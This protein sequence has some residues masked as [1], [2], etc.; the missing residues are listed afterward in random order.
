MDLH[1]VSPVEFDTAL[2]EIHFSRD[3][4]ER[5]LNV[6]LTILHRTMGHRRASRSEQWCLNDIATGKFIRYIDDR[7]TIVS[8]VDMVDAANKTELSPETAWKFKQLS[9]D[10]DAVLNASLALAEIELD[11]Q[12]R[13]AVFLAR[14]GWARYFSTKGT[15]AHTHTSM[16]CS[17]CNK[18]KNPTEFGW[19]PQLSGMS[20]EEAVKAL[21]PI[22][23]TVCYPSAPVEWTNGEVIDPTKCPGKPVEGS[24][25]PWRH[26]WNGRATRY[27]TCD[28]CGTKTT[29]DQAGKLRKH[30]AK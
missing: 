20:E 15:N 24:V 11:I 29:V 9:K 18:G 17:T 5:D 16:H 27:G 28:A 14:G 2:A 8:A 26:S 21:G 12:K 1:T 4:A 6:A 13:D 23:C 3:K 22:M 7:E 25:G 19:N 10:L 30:K